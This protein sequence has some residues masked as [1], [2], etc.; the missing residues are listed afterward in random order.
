MKIKCII[1][2]LLLAAAAVPGSAATGQASNV[3]KLG[4]NNRWE[5]FT[6]KSD[7]LTGTSGEFS[8][9]LAQAPDT[10]SDLIV[11]SIVLDYEGRKSDTIRIV[12]DG[13][14]IFLG[15]A[16]NSLNENEIAKLTDNQGIRLRS[17]I[18]YSV[19]HGDKEWAVGYEEDVPETAVKPAEA[20]A[21]DEVKAETDEDMDNLKIIAAA[22][23]ALAVIMIILLI[24]AAYR[25]GSKKS[26]PDTQPDA[27]DGNL[28]P[29]ADAAPTPPNPAEPAD[30][31]QTRYNDL[32]LTHKG[33][34]DKYRKLEEGL[35]R[36]R[37]AVGVKIEAGL[38]EDTL[39]AYILQGI[40]RLKALSTGAAQL[41]PAITDSEADVLLAKARDEKELKKYID[42][43][44][45]EDKTGSSMEIMVRFFRIIAS[46]LRSAGAGPTVVSKTIS[47]NSQEGRKLVKEWLREQYGPI[48]GNSISWSALD[49]TVFQRIGDL[50]NEGANPEAK[51][52]AVNTAIADIIA[53]VNESLPE[54]D[55]LPAAESADAFADVLSARLTV[56]EDIAEVRLKAHEEDLRTVSA[57]IGQPVA[58]MSADSIKDAVSRAVVAYL[59]SVIPA[60]KDCKTT[61]EASARLEQLNEAEDSLGLIRQDLDSKIKSRDEKHTQGATTDVI[62]LI[63]RYR[64]LLEDSEKAKDEKIRTT[65]TALQTAESTIAKRD[66]TIAESD[67]TIE[68]DN[69]RIN[70]LMAEGAALT[71]ALHSGTRAIEKAASA[72]ILKPCRNASFDMCDDIEN[73]LADGVSALCDRLSAYAA[74]K[75]A[76]P[77][78][79]RT[80]IHTLLTDAL[81]ADHSAFNTIC[82]YYAYSRLPFMTDETRNYGL[83]F[84]RPNIERLFHALNDLMVRFGISLNVPML[85]VA[86]CTQ[87]FDDIR[88]EASSDL[89]NL[90]PNSR[91]FRSD[92]A[93]DDAG[94]ALIVDIVEIGYSIDG[95]QVKPTSVLT[96]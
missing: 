9:S 82:R 87:E 84:N 4:D 65:E 88:G 39:P 3:L 53:K 68:A 8:K 93:P 13:T 49:S 26:K 81:N 95:E 80:E 36:I 12:A 35:D 76:T 73:R 70:T 96:A 67:A 61:E 7:T 42:D 10:L 75:D 31:L 60:F 20:E 47:L 90:C 15:K 18:M 78:E 5:L 52:M 69:K 62:E 37:A 21:T 89:D 29:E 22:G 44:E 58:S 86:S 16:M 51:Q 32:E 27:A 55:R 72:A 54:N 41:P 1:S 50:L 43:A 77:S 6:T 2:A 66:R 24:I 38:N 17:G 56:P 40:E 91:N 19:T 11:E 45:K 94:S 25:A 64:A 71:D 74:P 28:E 85:F 63:D 34:L 92:I 23:W 30:D 57:A 83:A 33:T 48:V 59:G 46:R 79:I 14:Q